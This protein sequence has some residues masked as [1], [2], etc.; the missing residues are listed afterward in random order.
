MV[1]KSSEWKKTPLS[2]VDVFTEGNFDV[3]IEPVICFEEGIVAGFSVGWGDSGPFG[4]DI[5]SSELKVY[6][7]TF[8]CFGILYLEAF[9]GSVDNGTIGGFWLMI[10]FRGG[11][12]TCPGLERRSMTSRAIVIR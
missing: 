5:S 8:F 2:P 9:D 7:S 10:E 12:I 4:K 6:H 1:S 11:A 3:L